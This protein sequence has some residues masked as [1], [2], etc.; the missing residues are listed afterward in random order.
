MII[1]TVIGGVL[2]FLYHKK[3]GCSTGSCP[4]TSNPYISTIYG[5]ILGLMAGS[6][7]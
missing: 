5:A 1:G 3:V 7:I 4:I 2:G 6:F